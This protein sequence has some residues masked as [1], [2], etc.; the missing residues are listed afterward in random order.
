M[1]TCPGKNAHAVAELTLG[2]VLAVDR[3]IADGVQMLKEQKWNKGF[4]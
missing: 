3:R 4:F 1:A 2:L